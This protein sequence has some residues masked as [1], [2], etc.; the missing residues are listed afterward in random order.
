MAEEFRRLPIGVQSF[1]IMRQENF[2]YVDKTA[3]FKNSHLM[4]KNPLKEQKA[5][6]SCAA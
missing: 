5:T 6:P 1:E 4:F 3:C 2:L